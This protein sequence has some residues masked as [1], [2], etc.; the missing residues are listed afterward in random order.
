[1]STSLK[2]LPKMNKFFSKK[3]TFAMRPMFRESSVEKTKKY[4][5]LKN[6]FYQQENMKQFKEKIDKNL[7]ILNSISTT[8]ENQ[9]SLKTALSYKAPERFNYDLCMIKKYD[10]NLD[11]N[12]SFISNFDLEADEKESLDDSFKSSDNEDNCLEQIEIKSRTTKKIFN[13]SDEINE[14]LEKEWNDIQELLLNKE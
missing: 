12:L 11:S 10:E 2:S 14:K 6:L 5:S 7:A 4:P 3:E 9:C 8:S 1:M 13:D